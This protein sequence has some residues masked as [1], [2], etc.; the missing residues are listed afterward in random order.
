MS[1][2][3]KS[4]VFE[5]KEKISTHFNMQK[6]EG[7]EWRVNGPKYHPNTMLYGI[8]K[9]D[10]SSS[11]D[12][13]EKNYSYHKVLCS[14]SYDPQK[15]KSKPYGDAICY[16][17]ATNGNATRRMELSRPDKYLFSVRLFPSQIRTHSSVFHLGIDYTEIEF[18]SI[19]IDMVRYIQETVQSSHLESL[20]IGIRSD[21]ASSTNI[22][23]G[24]NAIFYRGLLENED[25]GKS[26]GVWVDIFKEVPVKGLITVNMIAVS[27]FHSDWT[28]DMNLK[29]IYQKSICMHVVTIGLNNIVNVGNT[30]HSLYDTEKVRASQAKEKMQIIAPGA[31]ERWV[32]S[33]K[34]AVNVTHDRNYVPHT[35]FKSLPNQ[36]PLMPLPTKPPPTKLPVKSLPTKPLPTK[37][38][39]TQLP[40]KSLPTKPLSTEPLSTKSLPIPEILS[41]E[42]TWSVRP[43]RKRTKPEK[44]EQ[45]PQY[46]N[47]VKRVYKN[48]TT[49]EQ[50]ALTVKKPKTLKGQ[51]AA[52]EREVAYLKQKLLLAENALKDD[53]ALPE[54]MEAV[55]IKGGMAAQTERMGEQPRELLSDAQEGGVGHEEEYECE[56]DEEG[57]YEYDPEWKEADGYEE[58]LSDIHGEGG[59][60]ASGIVSDKTILS[61]SGEFSEMQLDNCMEQGVSVEH[62]GEGAYDSNAISFVFEMGSGVDLSFS[63]EEDILSFP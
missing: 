61:E 6:Y 54:A 47:L 38:P 25:G 40:V 2:Q 15:E 43:M 24:K 37:P 58:G 30:Y 60:A 35:P 10:S 17:P 26:L 42:D 5:T 46:A 50:V 13:L 19:S 29:S 56:E 59:Q 12:G 36:L 53:G 63:H 8:A 33:G 62:G 28:N 3:G 14:D 18:Q 57:G 20:H 34:G 1:T 21:L 16:F 44:L 23:G 7:S 49:S 9:G 27:Y 41:E 11:A 48:K 52:L 32:F 31:V 39:P 22:V 4:I 55:G 51:V 45:A